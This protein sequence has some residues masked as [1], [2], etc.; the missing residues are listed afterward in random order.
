[1]TDQPTTSVMPPVPDRDALASTGHAG[2][3][4][5]RDVPLPEPPSGNGSEGGAR[6]E[7]LVDALDRATAAVLARIDERRPAIVVREELGPVTD[8]AIAALRTFR[9]TSGPGCWCS[10]GKRT[11]WKIERRA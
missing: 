1:M 8:E 4:L 9:C 5:D 11:A 10:S 7:D 3:G 2:P 6:R